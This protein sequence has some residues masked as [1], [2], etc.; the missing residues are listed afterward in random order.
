MREGG[1]T[2]T[3]QQLETMGL[4]PQMLRGGEPAGPQEPSALPQLAHRDR[5]EARL[6]SETP[7]PAWTA[8]L[9]ETLRESIKDAALAPQT[10]EQVECTTTLCRVRLRFDD[11]RQAMALGD[12]VE[13]QGMDRRFER[14]PQADDSELW[15]VYLAR[16]G[17]TLDEGATAGT[18]PSG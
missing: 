14:E 4:A 2:L 18:P 9:R 11:L 12:F 15:T 16:D 8:S 10:L 13:R 5:F 7:D 17:Q 1:G 3:L 6:Q